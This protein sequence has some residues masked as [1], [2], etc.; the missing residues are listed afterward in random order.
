[1]IELK[2][3]TIQRYNQVNKSNRKLNKRIDTEIVL[4][5]KTGQRVNNGAVPKRRN[6]AQFR[7]YNYFAILA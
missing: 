5:I 6:G 3:H 2:L 4:V 1:M 7:L